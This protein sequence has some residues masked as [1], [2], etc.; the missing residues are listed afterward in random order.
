MLTMYTQIDNVKERTEDFAVKGFFEWKESDNAAHIIWNYMQVELIY[1]PSK[2][3]DV[4]EDPWKKLA[5]FLAKVIIN[6]AGELDFDALMSE[7]E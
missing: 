2:N 6:H 5:D 1:D 3:D 4:C 7:K